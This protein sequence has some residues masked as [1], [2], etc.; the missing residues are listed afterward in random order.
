MSGVVVVRARDVMVN[1]TE[2]RVTVL[3][4]AVDMLEIY[5]HYIEQNKR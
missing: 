2:W 4:P 1:P 5:R 3:L